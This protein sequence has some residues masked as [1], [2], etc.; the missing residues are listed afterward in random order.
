VS[1]STGATHAPHHVA[2]AWADKYKGQFD[3]GWDVYRE[4]TLERQKKHG[5]VPADTELTERPDAYPS[6]TASRPPSASST[7]G[8][9]RNV[10]HRRVRQQ[11]GR[12]RSP[13]T[14]V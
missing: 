11:A 7:P 5:I 3:D 8:R 1:R 14:E 13:A 10:A 4:K 6:W 2:K 9:W 12:Y